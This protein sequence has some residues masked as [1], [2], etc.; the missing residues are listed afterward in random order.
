[1]KRFVITLLLTLLCS[2][3]LHAQEV[4]LAYVDFPPY[5]YEEGGQAKGILVD[6]VQKIFDNAGIKLSL[7]FYPFKRAFEM[8]KN[9]EINGLFNLYKNEERLQYFDYTE[10]L[11][12]NPLVFFVRKD[13]TISYNSLADLKGL[14]IGAMLGYTYGQDFDNNTTFTRDDSSSHESNIKKLTMGRNDAYLCDKLVG[15]YTAMS[16]NQMSEIKIL[17]TPFKIMDG[18]IGFGK[19]KNQDTIQKI[20]AVIVKMKESGEIEKMIDQYIEKM[21]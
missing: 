20:N 4:T 18:H 3:A 5:E 6:I 19:G 7:K 13:S 2:T 17:P 9:G 16:I 21:K 11:I 1:M 8:A 10:P 12:K 14:K 15:I